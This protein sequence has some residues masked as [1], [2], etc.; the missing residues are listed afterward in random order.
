MGINRST[1]PCDGNVLGP[2]GR[3]PQG[4]KRAGLASN[5]LSQ[6]P[7]RPATVV[8]RAQAQP[9]WAWGRAQGAGRLTRSGAHA[10]SDLEALCP[11]Q[12]SE[13]PD[14]PSNVGFG[15][16][17]EDRHGASLEHRLYAERTVC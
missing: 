7:G 15:P 8:P 9:G 2:Q 3:V 16:S 13:R 6:G 14:A 5:G 12:A 10:P 17:M 4:G 11:A 1:P